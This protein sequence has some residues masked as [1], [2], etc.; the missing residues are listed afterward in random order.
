MD[1][2]NTFLEGSSIHGLSY[3]STTRKYA[4]LFWIF[5]VV[6][7]F[8]G[9]GLLI[10]SS[11]ESWSENPIQTTVETL[12]I[13]DIKFPKVTVCPPKN[14]FTDLNY[15]LMMTENDTLTEEMRDEMFKYAI[16]VIDENNFLEYNW[17]KLHEEDRFLN[18]YRGYTAITSPR[19]SPYYFYLENKINTCA[20]SGVIST[21]YF[22]EQFH[23][24]QV[25]RKHTCNIN[26][27][28]PEYVKLD[29]NVT[30]HYQVEK[31]SMTVFDVTDETYDRIIIRGL[32]NVAT[33]ITN[34]YKNFT[35]PGSNAWE[36]Q[37]DMTLV[38]VMSSEQVEKQRLDLMPGFRF[39]WWY[40]GAE[41]KPCNEYKDDDM[42]RHF[43]R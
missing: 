3:I 38:R 7:G 2:L 22:G 25:E 27:R 1:G 28:R 12:P 37:S 10:K 33:D 19:I 11:F 16:E 4:R 18:W 15:D 14:T 17:N 41:V 35:P 21:L 30:L 29:E 9:G 13:A 24:E 31:I 6:S 5:V 32:G 23:P 20:T 43:V 39:S 40:T 42:N 36:Y 34:A 26:I 8:F